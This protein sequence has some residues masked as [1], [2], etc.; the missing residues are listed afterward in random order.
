[1]VHGDDFTFSGTKVELDRMK[2]KMEEW[3]DIKDRGTMGGGEGEIKEVTILERTVRWTEE[4]IEYE[5]DAEHRAKLMKAEGLEEDFKVAVGPAVK[6]G[7]GAGA[8]EEVKLDGAS[9]HKEFRSKGATINYLGQ[10]PIDIQ[11]AVT[12]ICQGMS[13]PTERGKAK[14]KRAERYLV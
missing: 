10:D 9:K 11:C 12:M 4:G 7:S 2:R 6:D 13:T 3:Y 1:M 8:L 14:M 5:A